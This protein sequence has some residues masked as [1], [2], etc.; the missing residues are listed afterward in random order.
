[1]MITGSKRI[2]VGSGP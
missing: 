2:I 1:M